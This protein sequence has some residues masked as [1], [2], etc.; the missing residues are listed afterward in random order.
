MDGQ[1]QHWATPSSTNVKL[2]PGRYLIE[3]PPTVAQY[4][5][6]PWTF[7]SNVELPAVVEYTTEKQVYSTHNGV[8]KITR[9]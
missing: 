6:S 8:L 5:A 3:G 4:N 7:E 2:T 9:L 1:G